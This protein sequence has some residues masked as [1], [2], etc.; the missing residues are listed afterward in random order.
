MICIIKGKNKEL[1]TINSQNVDIL[2]KLN[3][4]KQ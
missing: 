1:S 3:I 4:Y 2:C